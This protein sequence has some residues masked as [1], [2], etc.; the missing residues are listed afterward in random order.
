MVE[1]ARS[2][3]SAAKFP[4]SGGAVVGLCLDPEKMVSTNTSHSEP[5]IVSQWVLLHYD[6]LHNVE[7][8]DFMSTGGAEKDDA[9]RR[10]RHHNN[11]S[12]PGRAQPRPSRQLRPKFSTE[13][14]HSLIQQ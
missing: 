11:H 8:R 1:V 5:E 6:C 12:E 10:V 9:E 2:L 14:N 13:N 7:G 4:G 3:G